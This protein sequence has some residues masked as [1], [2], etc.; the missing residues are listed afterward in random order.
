LFSLRVCMT[1]SLDIL[2][3]IVSGERSSLILIGLL[4]NVT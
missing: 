3:S 2:A 1:A 4:F